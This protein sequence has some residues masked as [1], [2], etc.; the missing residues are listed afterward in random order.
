[1]NRSL[2]GGLGAACL[3]SLVMTV[4]AVA[5][6]PYSDRSQIDAKYKWTLEDI[7]ADNAA[8]EADFKKLEATIP[9]LAGFQGHL[10]DGAAGL[11]AALEARDGAQRLQG[12][13]VVYA[14][15]RYDQDT[16]DETYSAMRDRAD[17]L[18]ARLGEALAYMEPEILVIPADRMQAMLAENR[19]LASYRHNL[20]T[21][22]RLRDHTLDAEGEKLMA[23]SS[24]VRGQ[25]ASVFGAFHNADVSYGTM[26]DEDGKEVELTKGL[27]QAFQESPDRRVREESWHLY[28]KAYD[29]FGRTLAAN[30]TGNV[31]A[32]VFNAKARGYDSALDASLYPNGVPVEVYKNLI[33]TVRANLEPLHRYVELRKRLLGVDTLQVWDMAAPLAAPTETDIPY[34]RAM[35][36]V[37][38][39]LAAL[40]S[41]Y[42]TPFTDGLHAGW[43]DVYETPGKRSGAYSWGTYDTKPYLLLNYN[44]T[45]DNVFTLAHEMGHSMQSWFSNHNQPYIYADYPIFTAEVASTANEAL[46]IEKLLAKTTDV[47]ERR[48]LLNHYLEQIRGTFF[49]QVL[50]ADV[51]LQMHETVENGEAL[52]R[53]KLDRIYNDTYAAYFGPALHIEPLNGAAWSRIPHFYYNFYMY[54]YATSYAAATAIAKAIMTEGNPAVQRLVAFLKAGGSD[55]PI[56]VLKI[57]G[58]DMA[59][60]RPILDTIATFSSLL[61]RMEAEL[62]DGE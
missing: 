16:R 48:F 60:P 24:E 56:E 34:D 22:L 52:T 20:D 53:E 29:E 42:M 15:M 17:A 27:Y 57:A 12:K 50:F 61:D 32:H 30:M 23:M 21:I 13:L 44:G 58:V 38:D 5:A 49:T 39:G 43:V 41:E 31:K 40:G 26:R 46:L 47:K 55:Y 10:G 7:Y 1:M 19:D 18:G 33:A 28:Y 4:P 37:T 36:I 2:V 25:F 6:P 8:W 62:A 45:L 9:G 54:Q 59:S 51:E 3:W 11:L 35:D 14:S